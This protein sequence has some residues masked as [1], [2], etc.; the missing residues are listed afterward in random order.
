VKPLIL[1]KHF[2]LSL[3]PPPPSAMNSKRNHALVG[4]IIDINVVE[5]KGGLPLII[6]MGHPPPPPTHTRQDGYMSFNGLRMQKT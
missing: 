5:M 3:G 1:D 4:L 6:V 2:S